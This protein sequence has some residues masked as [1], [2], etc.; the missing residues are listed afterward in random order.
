MKDHKG[1]IMKIAIYCFVAVVLCMCDDIGQANN[2][3]YFYDGGND[4]VISDASDSDNFDSNSN[5][6]LDTSEDSDTYQ[7]FDTDWIDKLKKSCE[8]VVCDNPPYDR[9]FDPMTVKTYRN[10][11]GWCLAGECI[12]RWFLEPCKR[13][14]NDE[15]GIICEF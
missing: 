13:C 15:F 14:I 5:E 3:E 4:S 9:C 8:G 6:G 2:W 12:Y 7:K 11:D 1:K 10:A